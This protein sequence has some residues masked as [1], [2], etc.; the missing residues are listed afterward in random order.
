MFIYATEKFDRTPEYGATSA[1]TDICMLQ[2]N[3]FSQFINSYFT[4]PKSNSTSITFLNLKTADG[5]I[6]M[7]TQLWNS[8]IIFILK[9]K[10][11]SYIWRC[12]NTSIE[13]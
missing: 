7:S 5:I 4:D 10:S 11:W 13:M 6:G 1:S 9:N 8:L 3:S 12:K 2:V